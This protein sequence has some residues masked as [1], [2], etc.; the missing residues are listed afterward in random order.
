VCRRIEVRF[1][2]P[3][4]YVDAYV[5]H[6]WFMPG[7]TEAEKERIRNSPVQ[8]CRLTYLPRREVWGFAFYKTS[9][10]TYEP[11]VTMRGSFEGT[12]EECL[13]TAGFAYLKDVW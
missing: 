5:N 10:D 3:Y 11:N 9:D 6:T 1:R 12:P 4:A 8:L 13:D 7:T 2:G